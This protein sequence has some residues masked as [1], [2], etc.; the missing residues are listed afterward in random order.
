MP[1]V[2]G[3][4]IFSFLVLTLIQYLI[5]RFPRFETVLY[6]LGAA[7]F[8]A[9]LATVR[10]FAVNDLT[11]A[12]W[13]DPVSW[14]RIF[15]VVIL[16]YLIVHTSLGAANQK[17]A[18]QVH[19][20]EAATTALEIQ[21][22][23]LISAGEDVRRQIADFLHDRLQSDLVLLG[24][25]M[26]R[27]TEKL[28]SEQRAVAQAYIDEIERIRQ[29]EVR[30]VSRQLAPELDGQSLKPAIEDLL[31]RYR[32]I[33]PTSLVLEE[34][35]LM[36]RAVKLACYRIIEQALLNVATHADASSVEVQL[37][38]QDSTVEIAVTDR[39]NSLPE[40]LTPG[41]G[42]AI[43]DDWTNQQSGHWSISHTAGETTLRVTLKF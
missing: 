32:K 14:P 1:S 38:E 8:G 43:Y 10:T 36:P 41:A 29:F 28:D 33:W 31:S 27:S 15:L 6:W 18:E 42:F 21:R 2:L 20:A 37:K 13:I 17:L 7:L 9:V 5:A 19:R 12:F 11:P 40:D 25:Q 26:R 3:G 4:L 34:T 30:D 16:I 24:I 22:R 23:R 35:G 39:G